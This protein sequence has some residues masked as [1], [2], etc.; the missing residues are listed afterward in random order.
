MPL[1]DLLTQLEVEENNLAFAQMEHLKEDEQAT[2]S[3][4]EG[5]KPLDE[6]PSGEGQAD[7]EPAPETEGDRLSRI[8]AE[9]QR[10]NERLARGE[11]VPF[12]ELPPPLPEFANRN[13]LFKNGWLRKGGAA[14][15]VSIS[16]SGK[17]VM[18]MQMI[19]AWAVGKPSLG[20][21]PLKPLKIAYFQTE[22]DSAD[23][24]LQRAGVL[25][26]MKEHEGWTDEDCR[27][28]QENADFLPPFFAEPGESFLN[29][30]RHYQMKE[31]YD[32]IVINPLQSFT[33]C[34]IQSNAEMTKFLRG[35]L[36]PIIK[37]PDLTCGLFIVHHTPKPPLDMRTRAAF[38]LDEFGEY[39][40]AGASELTNWIRAMLTIIP[41]PKHHG[42]FYLTGV[43]RD[44]RLGWPIP[45]N[46][47]WV[48]PRRI[49]AHTPG[50]L[51]WQTLGKM[52]DAESEKEDERPKSEIHAEV[53]LKLVK[54]S[55]KGISAT[56]LR[57]QAKGLKGKSKKKLLTK[58]EI[59]EA[60]KCLTSHPE[61]YGIVV[62][63]GDR[64][65]KT[66]RQ[67]KEE[68]VVQ[69][70]LGNPGGED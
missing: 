24:A 41:V 70:N 43:K 34:E 39:S 57:E 48:K 46:L 7:A 55:M 44:S 28:S 40:G 30:M 52:P 23:L 66:F 53:L 56:D 22:D 10:F 9:H 49:I 5:L 25:Q 63:R 6:E 38:G 32:L 37:N 45:E 61:A 69:P 17:S 14:M 47:T 12:S 64:N 15:L 3:R 62:E 1:D 19:C 36:D 27:L 65:S 51:Y 67:R 68:E 35:G 13:R 42:I 54:A 21:E 4:K 60:I 11:I 33:G 20:I 59:E 29:C 2:L 58:G 16:G 31:H 50:Y 26:G 18:I 8:D